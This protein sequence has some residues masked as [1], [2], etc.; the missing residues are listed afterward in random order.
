MTG[1]ILGGVLAAIALVTAIMWMVPVIDQDT[2]WFGVRVPGDR[3]D[4]PA[5]VAALGRYRRHVA[6]S[7]A[8]AAVT[9]VALGPWAPFGLWL[10]LT[11]GVLATTL[12]AAYAHAHRTVRFAKVRGDWYAGKRAGV[13]VD[14]TL[15]TEP[16]PVAWW[17]ALPSLAIIAVV[18]VTGVVS[19]P[20]LPDELVVAVNYRPEGLEYVTVETT[21]L[22]AFGPVMIQAAVTAL[23]LLVL[24]VT[25]RARAELDP[26]RPRPSVLRHR[27]F[28][29]IWSYSL[30]AVML[31]QNLVLATVALLI[32][33]GSLRD[34]GPVMI[35]L[36]VLPVVAV[37]G[38]VW[39]AA[40][41]S[42]QGGWRLRADSDEAG[43]A[44]DL[45]SPDDDRHWRVGGLVY[46]NREDPSML[47]QKRGG[48]GWTVNLGHRSVLLVAAAVGVIAVATV[49]TALSVG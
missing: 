21:V 40:L 32:W 12:I 48:F 14:T 7:G 1:P 13:A 26:A 47:V 44:T 24:W 49:V 27:R 22:S 16:E 28:L 17:A 20:S 10:A 4:D 37:S 15:R 9:A 19:Y 3:A 11:G 35:A 31:A 6:G 8:L 43:E 39:A 25:M 5:I 42:G 23:L 34:A 41:R 33:T 45:V 46:V 38:L 2:I 36:V 29:R 18:A 30:F